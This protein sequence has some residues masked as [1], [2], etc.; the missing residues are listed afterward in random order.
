MSITVPAAEAAPSPAAIAASSPA[1]SPV[2]AAPPAAS[3][4]SPHA[5]APSPA[6][7]PGSTAASPVPESGLD[8]PELAAACG[9]AELAS[10]AARTLGAT[11]TVERM[12]AQQ[13]AASHRLAMNSFAVAIASDPGL[14]AAEGNVSYDLRNRRNDYTKLVSLMLDQFRAGHLHLMRTREIAARLRGIGIEAS[15]ARSRRRPAVE[16]S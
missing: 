8:A 11:N 5:C 3:S 2:A 14:P 12:L 9:V 1:I 15:P 13:L 7:S 16:P 10:E 4:M 6:P